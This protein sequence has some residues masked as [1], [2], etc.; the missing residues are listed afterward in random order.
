MTNIHITY[1]TLFISL[2]KSTAFLYFFTNTLY[3]KC[4][5]KATFSVQIH[6]GVPYPNMSKIA[7]GRKLGQIVVNWPVKFLTAGHVRPIYVLF[8]F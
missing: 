2:K 1:T 4:N 8:K 7:V 6:E 5:F 3:D